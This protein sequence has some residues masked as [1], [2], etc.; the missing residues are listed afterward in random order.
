MLILLSDQV[1]R[2]SFIFLNYFFFNIQ[3]FLLVETTSL[4]EEL[5]DQF[6]RR[7]VF[8]VPLHKGISNSTTQQQLAYYF[9]STSSLIEN[10]KLTLPLESIALLRSAKRFTKKENVSE[11]MLYN[12]IS[13]LIGEITFSMRY[14]SPPKIEVYD[15]TDSVAPYPRI[16]YLLASTSNLIN[17]S[18][19]EALEQAINVIKIFGLNYFVIIYLAII[20]FGEL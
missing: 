2:I 11:T 1:N 9:A 20:V 3:Y 8:A 6:P 16:H 14:P 15:V 17:S 10:S 12:Y 4:L 7:D 18:L 13:H 5:H 19:E